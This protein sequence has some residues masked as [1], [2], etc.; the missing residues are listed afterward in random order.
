MG[1][2]AHF[3][4]KDENMNISKREF[5]EKVAQSAIKYYDKYKILPSLVIAQACKESGFGV[6]DCSGS[7]NFFGMKWTKT[8]G[9][10][11]I[12]LSTKEWDGTKY[13]TIKSKFRKYNSFDE[14]IEGYYKFITGYKRYANLIGESDPKKIC[15]LIQKDGYATSPTYAKSLYNDYV[16]PYNLVQYNRKLSGNYYE[17]FDTPIDTTPID[18]YVVKK[19]DSLWSIA[20]D[21]LGFGTK[22]KKIYDANKLNT[23]SIYPGQK[24]IIPKGV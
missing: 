19:G 14:G 2:C 22:W 11:Y 21:K 10:D 5:I 6:H 20:H 1:R 7:Y 17:V 8:C 23:T 24:L 4:R 13:I 12:E 15:E 16:L 3:A 18:Y 9:C